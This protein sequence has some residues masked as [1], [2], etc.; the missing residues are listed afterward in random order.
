MR[1]TGKSFRFVRACVR[2]RGVL[3]LVRTRPQRRSSPVP[4]SLLVTTVFPFSLFGTAVFPF[5]LGS[6][7]ENRW[8]TKWAQS[9][10]K[11]RM[12]RG[13][14]EQS[15]TNEN[16]IRTDWEQSENRV[17]TK[18]EERKNTRKPSENKVKTERK[19][20]E[21]RART[22]WEWSEN[23]RGATPPPNLLF[24]FSWLYG[25]IIHIKAGLSR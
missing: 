18:W 25:Y 16:Q 17:R 24:N 2:T 19:Q 10:N 20:S 21:I 5:S 13:Q 12:K 7:S 14:W 9:E 4:F 22:K 11:E 15:E 6:I 8:R 23:I 3:C 1:P